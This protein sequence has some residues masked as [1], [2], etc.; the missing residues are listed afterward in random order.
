[1]RS[2]CAVNRSVFLVVC[3]G[4]CWCRLRPRR[5]LKYGI[6]TGTVGPRVFLFQL[7]CQFAWPATNS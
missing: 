2:S 4:G 3:P 7:L 6:S 5:L 1:M